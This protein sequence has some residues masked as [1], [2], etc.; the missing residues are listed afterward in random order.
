MIPIEHKRNKKVFVVGLGLSGISAARALILGG[1]IVLAWDDDR[2][3]RKANKSIPGL[4]IVSPD[5]ADFTDIDVVVLSPGIPLNFPVPHKVV[6]LARNNNISIIGDIQLFMDELVYRKYNNKVIMVTGTNGKSTT[7]SLINHL[8]ECLGKNVELGGNIGSKSVLEFSLPKEDT[9]YI[10]EISSYQIELSP[11][12]RPNIA[13]L[14]NITPDHLDR[15]SNLQ[16]YAKIK[17]SIF[18][19]QNNQDYAIIG[20]KSDL[21]LEHMKNTDIKSRV[22]ILEEENQKKFV[23]EDGQLYDQ[24]YLASILTMETLGYKFDKFVKFFK[25][26]KSLRHR[27][28]RIKIVKKIEFINDSKSTNADAAKYALSLFNNIYWIL[29]GIQKDDGISNITNSFKNVRKAYLIGSSAH[30]FKEVLTNNGIESVIVN[31]LDKAVEQ[32]IHDANIS[33]ITSTILFS[34][35]CSSFDQYKNFEIRG[36]E[37]CNLVRKLSRELI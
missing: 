32:S 9:V 28:E 10:I 18:K 16:N 4:I 7:A 17:F 13:I 26:Y 11:R 36:D 8:L 35:A 23:Q 6:N 15:H 30:S 25:S 3:T 22:C 12:I 34:P 24:N 27:V 21:I 2:L 5:D 37:F 29:G 31:K 19:N 33:G 20:Q 1:A 14:L